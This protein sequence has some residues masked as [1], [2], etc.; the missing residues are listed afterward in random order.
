M[1]KGEYVDSTRLRYGRVAVKRVTQGMFG[2]NGVFQ[3]QPS[4]QDSLVSMMR[5]EIRVLRSFKHPSIIKLLG[6]HMPEG[7]NPDLGHMCLVY[8]MASNGS[9]DTWLRD[10]T[11]AVLLDWRLRAKIALGIATALNYLHCRDAGNPA[12]HRDVKSGNIA[13]TVDFCPKLLDCGLAKFIP[14]DTDTRTQTV[15]TKT[16]SIFGTQGYMCP[17]Y[18]NTR[19]YDAKSEIYSFGIVLTEL[20]GGKVQ[21]QDGVHIDDEALSMDEIVSDPRI[22]DV[23]KVEFLRL[24]KDLSLNC[25]KPYRYRIASML[26]VMQELRRM[27]DTT[28]TVVPGGADA[29]MIAEM[30]RLRRELDAIRLKET[31]EER[32]QREDNVQNQRICPVCCDNFPSAD[33]V[34]CSQNHF[35]CDQCFR[36]NVSQQISAENRNAF[37][38]IDTKISCSFCPTHP[39]PNIFDD[40]VI[41]GHLGADI[42]TQYLTARNEV[43]EG[44]QQDARRVDN[45]QQRLCVICLANEKSVAVIPCGH[46]LY[47][48][49]CATGAAGR[50]RECPMDR[51]RVTGTQ[52][53]FY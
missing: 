39:R 20:F 3:P 51:Q 35:L 23:S 31:V 40:T 15:L 12:Y 34:E 30:N 9:L 14:S 29:A 38:A 19:I 49:D 10:D 25:I 42:F 48:V 36:N 53:V 22:A 6:F 52:R 37:I 13:L 21:N 43:T 24:W 2:A 11:K 18:V 17:Q 27:S 5:R 45:D 8:E 50:L 1:Y 41:A 47:C 32:L 28:F 7:D 33:G 4:V 46:I 26:T 44:H 16:S